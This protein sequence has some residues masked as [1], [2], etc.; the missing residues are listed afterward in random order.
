MNFE[1]ISLSSPSSGSACAITE[2]LK[3]YNNFYRNTNEFFD[4]IL[5]SFKSINEI[6]KGQPIEFENKCDFTGLIKFKNFDFLI[7]VHSIGSDSCKTY[8]DKIKQHET[9]IDD[10]YSIENYPDLIDMLKE[11]YE[12]K[13][14]RFINLLKK[15]NKFYFVRY[16]DNF[17]ESIENDIEEFFLLL[18]QINPNIDPKLILFTW[19]SN[20][21][22]PSTFLSQHK[23]IFT[24]NLNNDYFLKDLGLSMIFKIFEPMI[25]SFKPMVKFI[26]DVEK[27]INNLNKNS[28]KRNKDI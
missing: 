27:S 16:C 7:E 9:L 18:K 11:K 6:L 17:N 3:R 26:D 23:N 22:F 21:I 24:L 2:S 4:Y 15:N 28:F 13:I 5:T 14:D 25:E 20:L 1:I 12:R 8:F 19:D 10:Y